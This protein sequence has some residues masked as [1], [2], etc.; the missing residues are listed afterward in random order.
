MRSLTLPL[1]LTALLLPAAGAQSFGIYG[2]SDLSG[3]GAGVQV[4]NAP[5][6][7]GAWRLSLDAGLNSAGGGSAELA[8][9]RL[10]RLGRAGTQNY[11]GA[12]VFA[13]VRGL[14]GNAASDQGL[15]GGARGFVGSELPV[16][17]GRLFGELGVQAAVT[18]TRYSDV[19]VAGGLFPLVR[20]GVRF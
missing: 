20:A 14:S 4:Q 12:G 5:S 9:D 16:G 2:H 18:Q 17:G 6:A 15:F 19:G 1:T 7:A 11:W 10:S 8:A 13:G 3:S